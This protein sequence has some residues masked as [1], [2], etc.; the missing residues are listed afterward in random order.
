MKTVLHK[1]FE[2][3][4][5][6][7]VRASLDE[8]LVNNDEWVENNVWYAKIYEHEKKISHNFKIKRKS[9]K[10][11][12]L[13]STIDVFCF[14]YSCDVKLNINL[15]NRFN[16]DNIDSN[17]IR[18][19]KVRKFETGDKTINYRELYVDKDYACELITKIITQREI[20]RSNYA[21]KLE[22]I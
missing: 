7:G 11:D 19:S 2:N 9:N 5:K 16:L 3:I 12:D 17:F 1:S 8:F 4:V 14:I 13:V 18:K 20:R 21:N 22:V 10:Y 15:I 6:D